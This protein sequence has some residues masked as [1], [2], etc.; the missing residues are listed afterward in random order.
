MILGN[1]AFGF[2]VG[3]KWDRPQNLQIPLLG[4]LFLAVN[5]TSRDLRTTG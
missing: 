3:L 1:S 5:A 2:V 4:G